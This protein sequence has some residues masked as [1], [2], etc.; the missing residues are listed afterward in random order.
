MLGQLT[1]PL[2]LSATWS[3]IGGLSCSSKGSHCE[4]AEH[5]PGNVEQSLCK[6]N[7]AC[8]ERQRELLRSE[9]GESRLEWDCDKS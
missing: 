6:G 4:T 2:Q 8:R 3:D 1:H 5:V 9:D 7:H